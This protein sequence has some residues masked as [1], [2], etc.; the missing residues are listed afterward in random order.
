MITC[1]DFIADRNCRKHISEWHNNAT[2]AF[3]KLDIRGQVRFLLDQAIA[4]HYLDKM[5]RIDCHPILTEYRDY[6]KSLYIG[7]ESILLKE[8]KLYQNVEHYTSMN[9]DVCAEISNLINVQYFNNEEPTL[10]KEANISLIY[11]ILFESE[12]MEK[13]PRAIPSSAFVS[14]FLS[15][16][17][18][19]KRQHSNRHCVEDTDKYT[20]DDSCPLLT[21]YFSCGALLIE[22]YEYSIGTVFAPSEEILNKDSFKEYPFLG[23]LLC[24]DLSSANLK[25]LFVKFADMCLHADYDLIRSNNHQLFYR[26]RSTLFQFKEPSITGNRRYFHDIEEVICDF[27]SY[28]V[29]KYNIKGVD[30]AF[31]AAL[32]ESN[33]D[34]CRCDDSKKELVNFLKCTNQSEVSNEMYNAFKISSLR[35][36][37][38]LD[39]F[40]QNISRVAQ[41]ALE[42][43]G[44]LDNPSDP[45]PADATDETTNDAELGDPNDDPAPADDPEGDDTPPADDPADPGLD[46]PNGD[47]APSDNPDDGEG[48]GDPE[49]TSDSTQ[50]DT[51]TPE[52]PQPN[53]SD[54]RGIVFELVSADDETVDSILFKEEME[55]YL[56]TILDNPPATMSPQH[57][58][59]LTCLKRYWLHVL[60]IST[61]QEIV[62]VATKLPV[63]IKNIKK[64]NGESPQ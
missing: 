27:I 43:E 11:F 31:I 62:A 38:Q 19:R 56:K 51:H 33:D 18:I 6:I 4:I 36:V 37:K 63:V 42:D 16:S 21:F 55:V 8:K 46:D 58:Q 50:D 61:I 35:N 32:M 14:T 30:R 13:T 47:Q 40:S 1:I 28:A 52:V 25:D 10:K 5:Y 12:W 48:S 49:G 23:Y 26:L 39:I 29:D 9:L 59:L 54:K 20:S 15:Y 7:V 22:K 64:S 24:F 41:E 3:H 45:A 34:E 57:V 53:T 17:N 2:D 60:S 44:D